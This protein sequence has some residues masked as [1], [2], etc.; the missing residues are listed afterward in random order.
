M[1]TREKILP[2][3]VAG[4]SVLVLLTGYSPSAPG[5]APSHYYDKG[6]AYERAGR[7]DRAERQ[8]KRAIGAHRLMAA[9]YLALGAV[10]LREGRL[11]EAETA[12]TNAIATLPRSGLRGGNYRQALSMAY[13]NLGVAAERKAALEV[14]KV[15]LEAAE[16]HR[17]EA[18]SLY[19]NALEINRSNSMAR[20]NLRRLPNQVGRG[21]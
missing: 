11:A 10:Y 5:A 8:F 9:A 20:V 3:C 19:R 7:Y 4:L 14:L 18:E 15:D 12:T 17:R 16:G 6:L 1:I 2:T 13:N 21:D